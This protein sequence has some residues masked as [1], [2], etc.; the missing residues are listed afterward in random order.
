MD[1]GEEKSSVESNAK[2]FYTPCPKSLGVAA[3][4]GK[5]LS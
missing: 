1:R 4:C 3:S 5:N 2:C